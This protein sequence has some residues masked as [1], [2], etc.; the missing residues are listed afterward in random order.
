MSLLSQ[1]SLLL[2]ISVVIAIDVYTSEICRVVLN[3]APGVSNIQTLFLA[4]NDFET[5]VAPQII[6][7]FN[8]I[9]PQ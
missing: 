8:V 5:L 1:A 9:I 6:E 3:Y 7:K 2:L 4:F